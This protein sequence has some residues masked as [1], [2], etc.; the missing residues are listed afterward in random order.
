MR[1]ERRKAWRRGRWAE[2][3]AALVLGLK[4]FRILARR[5]RTT[6]GEIDLIAKR[7]R[8]I[9]FVE[10]KARRNLDE[11][12]AAL[13]PYGEQRIARAADLWIARHPAALAC[14]LRFDVVLVAPRRFPRHI[15]DAFRPA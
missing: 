10:V 11:A 2:G 12:R 3:L 14:T 5:F 8:L 9:A 4:G 6:S 1:A 13:T 15:T 7:G